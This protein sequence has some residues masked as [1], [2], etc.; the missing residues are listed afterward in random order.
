VKILVFA[1]VYRPQQV[2]LR[3][4]P[5]VKQSPPMCCVVSRSLVR[6]QTVAVLE[7]VVKRIV[8]VALV[9]ILLLQREIGFQMFCC[10]C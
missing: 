7:H 9:S 3:E 8:V 4:L 10:F 6:L 5:V 1:R 2:L